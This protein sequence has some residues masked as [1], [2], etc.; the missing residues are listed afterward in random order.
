MIWY[1]LHNLKNVKNI[2]GGVLLC[3]KFTK[4]NTPAWVF[5][6]FFKLYKW[7]QIAQHIT[8][9]VYSIPAFSNYQIGSD[10]E[11]W[12]SARYQQKRTLKI[13]TSHTQTFLKRFYNK[14]IFL[15]EGS[16]PESWRHSLSWLGPVQSFEWDFCKTMKLLLVIILSYCSYKAVIVVVLW[17]RTTWN[18]QYE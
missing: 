13:S 6:T 5:F 15:R 14:K 8:C 7:Y 11:Y 16:V 18:F 10:L 1:H 9:L 12:G 17:K 4:S 2:H 3:C